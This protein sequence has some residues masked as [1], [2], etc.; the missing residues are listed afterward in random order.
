[1]QLNLN[2]SR[3]ILLILNYIKPLIKSN[4]Q[5]DKSKKI[6]KIS[7]CGFCYQ[8]RVNLSN[9]LIINNILALK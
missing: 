2:S 5:Q 4:Q 6:F 3:L 7:I 8:L 1:M 9:L